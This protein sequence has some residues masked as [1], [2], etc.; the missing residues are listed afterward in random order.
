MSRPGGL[1]DTL[2]SPEVEFENLGAAA[3]GSIF[4]WIRILTPHQ[5]SN[6]RVDNAATLIHGSRVRR[7][8]LARLNQQGEQQTSYRVAG[9]PHGRGLKCGSVC[10]FKMESPPGGYSH[11][12]RGRRQRRE[13]LPHPRFLERGAKREGGGFGSRAEP[14]ST[15]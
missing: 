13:H 14:T 2:H 6:P 11:D 12:K 4:S 7:H 8:E 1:Q 10:R 5:K 15:R 3:P 9:E